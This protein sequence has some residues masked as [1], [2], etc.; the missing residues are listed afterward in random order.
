MRKVRTDCGATPLAGPR[1]MERRDVLLLLAAAVVWGVNFAVVKAGL[2]S[3]PPLQNRR[4]HVVT[5]VTL[6]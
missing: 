4:A 2:R 5:P 3:M 1:K 6:A